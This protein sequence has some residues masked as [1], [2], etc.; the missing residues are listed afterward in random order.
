L[1]VIS[2]TLKRFCEGEGNDMDD[3]L[4]AILGDKTDKK[5]WLAAS[6][7]KT[8]RLHQGF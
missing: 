3:D 2:N 7:G 5:Q 6:L 1:K 4:L 8:I